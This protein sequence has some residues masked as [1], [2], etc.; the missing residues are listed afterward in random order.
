[1]RGLLHLGAAS[2]RFYSIVIPVLY[3]S[4]IVEAEDEDKLYEIKVGPSLHT[5]NKLLSH[6]KDIEISSPIDTKLANRCIHYHPDDDVSDFIY[7]SDDRFAELLERIMPL[8][9][10]CKTDGLRSFRSVYHISF[11]AT[12]MTAFQ[13]DSGHMH[14]KRDIGIQWLPSK[15]SSTY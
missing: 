4:I 11:I 13:L 12:I 6:V 2:K 5:P 10:G 8:L 14:T 1:M 9:R 3:E 7:G 15:T